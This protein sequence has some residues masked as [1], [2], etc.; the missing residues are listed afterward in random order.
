MQD[1]WTAVAYGRPVHI[2]DE[3]WAVTDLTDA[4]FA[5]CDVPDSREPEEERRSMTRTGKHHFM[6]MVR[7]ST[8]LSDVL[9]EFYA[10]KRSSEQDTRILYQR[11]IPILEKL[12]EWSLS[13]PENLG[14]HVTYQRRLCFHGKYSK[15]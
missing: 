11:A 2:H 5:D 10:V 12:S 6:L 15:R 9:S 7:L 8:I 13:V 3:D 4:D 14:M 1:R